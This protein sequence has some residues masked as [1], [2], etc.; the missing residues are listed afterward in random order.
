MK[1]M[2]VEDVVVEE[3]VEEGEAEEKKEE[4]A[5]KEEEE[6]EKEEVSTPIKP[7]LPSIV[8]VT[9][10]P[11]YLE[12]LRLRRKGRPGP[13]SSLLCGLMNIFFK[14]KN[15]IPNMLILFLFDESQK[16]GEIIVIV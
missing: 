13:G 12:N 16:G 4:A 8:V 15:T 10:S 2:V 14:D 6:K 3:E 9:L 1:G 5:M 7:A 11:L